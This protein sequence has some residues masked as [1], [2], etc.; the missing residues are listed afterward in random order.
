MTNDPI[1][2]ILTVLTVGVAIA[3]VLAILA[4]IYDDRF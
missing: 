2:V 4:V 3:C 1:F